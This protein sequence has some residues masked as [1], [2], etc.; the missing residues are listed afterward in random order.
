MKNDNKTF[1]ID[2]PQDERARI[3]F[4]KAK[5]EE[6]LESEDHRWFIN[7]MDPA[8]EA[9]RKDAQRQFQERYK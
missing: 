4:L 6:V 5:L 9:R 3:E 7:K 1:P 8:E 2:S